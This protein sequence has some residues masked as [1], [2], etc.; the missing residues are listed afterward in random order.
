VRIHQSIVINKLLTRYL[1]I[2][3]GPPAEEAQ[4]ELGDGG[5]N[6]IDVI[7]AFQLQSIIFDKESYIAHLKGVSSLSVLV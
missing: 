7:D 6:I 3:A 1:D 5:T 2:G 4:E